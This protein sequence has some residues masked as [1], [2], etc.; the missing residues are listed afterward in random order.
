MSSTHNALTKQLGYAFQD[1]A[2]LE[3][4]LT[5]RSRSSQN[6]ERLEFLGDSILSFVIADILYDRFPQLSEGELTRLRATLVRRETLAKLAR[7]LDLGDCLG[8]GG[9]ELKSGGFDRD[10]ILADALEA[11]F[12][13]VYKDGGI[14]AVREVVLRR[15]HPVLDS[16]DPSSILKDSKTRLQEFLQRRSLA[17][18][19]YTVLEVSG[20][21]HQQHFVVECHVPGLAQTVRGE[22]GSRRYAEQAAATRACELLN[23]EADD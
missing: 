7:K 1:E 21:P 11:V 17:T 3:R 15:Y 20:E 22:G 8:L 4:A 10:S 23:C 6:Y 5:H 13:A 2:L 12:G 18:P 16:I 19:T 9:G 14:E